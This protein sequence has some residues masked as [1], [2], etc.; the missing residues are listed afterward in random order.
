[1]NKSD[2]INHLSETGNFSKEVAVGVY[3]VFVETL[4]QSLLTND[5]KVVLPE[6]GRFELKTRKPRVGVNPNTGEKLEIPEKKVIRFK[7]SKKV[8]EEMNK[9]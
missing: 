8:S 2:F 5:N 1:M 9:K 4:K 3:K 6:L 7:E